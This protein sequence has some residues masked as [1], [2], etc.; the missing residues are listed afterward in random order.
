MT[1]PLTLAVVALF[2][3]VAAHAFVYAGNPKLTLEV[4]SGDDL[5]DG[6]VTL[7]VVRV[8]ACGGGSTDYQVNEE[9][10]P[11]A[12]YEL[13]IGGGDLCSVT[14]F[15]S[16]DMLLHGVEGGVPFSLEHVQ[17]STQVDISG[18][19]EWTALPT[20]GVNGFVYAGNPKLHVTVQ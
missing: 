15:W 17:S 14:L 11:V 4:E 6:E 1:R 18:Q 13:D 10:D 5:T 9:I 12:G 16:D 2:T 8:H 20:D 19:P 3:T 7:D